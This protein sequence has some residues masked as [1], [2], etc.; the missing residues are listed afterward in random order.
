MYSFPSD[1]KLEE[2]KTELIERKSK[3]RVFCQGIRFKC[4]NKNVFFWRHLFLSAG[5]RHKHCE[6][7]WS[8]RGFISNIEVTGVA[9]CGCTKKP[10]SVAS[11]GWGSSMINSMDKTSHLPATEDIR[12]P[13]RRNWKS[14]RRTQRWLFSL[15]VQHTVACAL[16]SPFTLLQI[17]ALFH[18]TKQSFGL[19][20]ILFQGLSGLC[21]QTKCG[22]DSLTLRSPGR[23][24]PCPHHEP[25]LASR[26]G[27]PHPKSTG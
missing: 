17:W 18:G 13:W 20:S 24:W 16:C 2:N 12:S 6:D 23:T 15:S 10:W 3:L 22:I 19:F 14:C 7:G 26:R 27:W 11:W 5:C 25:P 4:Y 21:L 8:K 9:T 1:N